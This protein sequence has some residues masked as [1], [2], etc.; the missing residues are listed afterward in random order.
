MNIVEQPE[1]ITSLQI[2]HVIAE[3]CK[4]WDAYSRGDV[5]EQI[6][7]GLRGVSCVLPSNTH[8]SLAKCKGLLNWIRSIMVMIRSAWPVGFERRRLVS[9]V[10]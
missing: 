8:W 10:A 7:S 9:F 5:V 2:P 4:G 1:N 3:T 6:D